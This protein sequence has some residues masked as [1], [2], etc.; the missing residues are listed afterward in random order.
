MVV[1]ARKRLFGGWEMNCARYNI[2]HD[3]KLPGSSS[4]ENSV[5]MY[6]NGERRQGRSIRSIP[7]RSNTRSARTA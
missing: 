5:L 2:A 3:V 4:G 6:P 7:T 1:A